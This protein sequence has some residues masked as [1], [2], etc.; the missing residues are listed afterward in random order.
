MIAPAYLKIGDSVGFVAPARSVN[1]DEV[2]KAIDV[3]EQHG[4][5]VVTGKNLFRKD[6]QFS[7]NDAER[8]SDMQNFID[9]PKIKAIISVRGGYGSVR[10]LQGLDFSKFIQQPKWIVGYSDVT[11]FHAY[12]NNKL[13]VETLH[14]PMP[15]NFGRGNADWESI[16][17]TFDIL[18][19]NIPNYTFESNILNKQG[20]SEGILIGGNLSVL[21]SLRGTPADFNPESKILFLEDI[22]EYL[23]HIDRMLMNFSYGQ[24]LKGLKA[25]IV[26]DMTDM[27]DNN[28]PF[29][30]SA[31]EIIASLFLPYNI[32]VCFG[33]SAGHG[34]I[35]KPLI[36]GRNVVLQVGNI[37][38]LSYCEK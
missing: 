22:D 29:G 25:V 38:Q 7:G 19:G 18:F 24:Q 1:R 12:C 6:N 4:L 28:I 26:G 3:F 16:E 2:A 21:Y 20:Q 23:Y 27:K 5:K 30:K 17:S 35:N 31:Y 11:V 8:A 13:Q 15:F 9:N 14:A 34:Q 10:T 33:F 37:C 36:M 32:P